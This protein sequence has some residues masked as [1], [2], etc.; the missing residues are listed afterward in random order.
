[1]PGA[2]LSI[3]WTNS[4]RQFERRMKTAD[5]RIRKA[6]KKQMREAAKVVRKEV[7]RRFRSRYPGGTGFTARKLAFTV[8][9]RGKKKPRAIAWIGWR[10]RSATANRPTNTPGVWHVPMAYTTLLE[11]GGRVNRKVSRIVGGQTGRRVRDRTGTIT[12]EAR[13][14]RAGAKRKRAHSATY[15]AKPF[16]GPGVNAKRSEVFRLIG[17]TFNVV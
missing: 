11:K 7:K 4:R 10:W 9:I 13:A 6:L 2:A 12:R 8:R 14:V 16:L 3:R 15:K 1:M 5:R 17:K